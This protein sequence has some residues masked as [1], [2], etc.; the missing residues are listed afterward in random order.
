MSF[1]IRFIR[2]SLSG[3]RFPVGREPL[4]VGRSHAC[5]IRPK[6]SD[7]SGKHLSL[8]EDGGIVSVTI[9][10]AH[11]TVVA[12]VRVR[13]GGAVPAP[14]GSVVELGDDLAFRVVDDAAAAD[15]TSTL[16]EQETGTL[17]GATE[18][19]ATAA[20]RF[21]DSIAGDDTG[22]F[23]DGGTGTA[24]TRFGGATGTLTEATRFGGDSS[25]GETGTLT[26]AT[27]FGA[28]T[29]SGE[30]SIL[31]GASTAPGESGE[32][33]LGETQVLETQVASREELEKIK[34]LY[35]QRQTRKIASKAVLLGMAVLAAVGLTL[36][37]SLQKP[38]TRL[39]MPSSK[40]SKRLLP[41]LFSSSVGFAGVVGLQYPNEGAKIVREGDGAF[42]IDV[43]IG[44][45]RDVAV[46]L[47]FEA[48]EDPLAV[49]ESRAST[50]D[51]YLENSEAMR[52]ALDEMEP[53][54]E[55]D[56]FGGRKGLRRGI[57][58]SRREYW[59][60]RD[61][62]SVYGVISFFRSGTL[63]C[64]FRREVTSFESER[65]VHLLQPT[66]VWL[67]ADRDGA[68][69]AAQW[70]GA[71]VTE[72]SASAKESSAK[73]IVADCEKWLDVDSTANWPILE[74]R[75]RNV[76][77]SLSGPEQDEPLRDQAR[78]L[79][80]KLRGAKALHWQ[81]L[82]ARRAPFSSKSASGKEIDNLVRKDFSDPAEEWYFLARR[83]EWWK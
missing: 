33:D 83:H 21:G 30:T 14:A 54:P 46:R 66:S 19:L 8:A 37:V 80:V 43:R 34:D 26:A 9:L 75:L 64:A 68:F 61:G 22:T 3:R 28:A 40:L 71:E 60:Q 25:G 51:R 29:E 67:F 49:K 52:V 7:V 12:G 23:G 4:L 59:C 56:F 74:T 55:E 1:S 53:L 16:P 17:P 58:C 82:T 57:P 10:S 47:A 31:A 81:K 48:F 78:S 11:R 45:K 24:A 42:E 18:G 44:K 63:C 77:A 72:N 38:E 35:Q 79:L 5:A 65:A 73:E 2:G 50:F 76:L 39:E 27:R 32:S 41:D 69:A 70:E 36:W 13:Q 62:E 15:E 20:T 6:E